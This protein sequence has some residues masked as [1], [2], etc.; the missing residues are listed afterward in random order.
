MGDGGGG[1]VSIGGGDFG[2]AAGGGP[3]P[4]ARLPGGFVVGGVV[5]LAFG[6]VS[7]D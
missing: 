7:L 6:V 5:G 2:V 3:S 4:A 1:L